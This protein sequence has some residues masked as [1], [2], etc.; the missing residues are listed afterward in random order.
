[1]GTKESSNATVEYTCVAV[2]RDDLYTESVRLRHAGGEV[3][4]Q[5]PPNEFAGAGFEV[6]KNYRVT[7]E[8]VATS[9]GD[10]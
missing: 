6:G 1:M 8:A 9:G 10:S 7:V 5:V 3:L 2:S 4:L